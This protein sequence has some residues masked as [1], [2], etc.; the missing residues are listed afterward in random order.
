MHLRLCY[1]DC[2]EAGP[3]YFLMIH[4]ENLLGLVGLFISICDAFIDPPSYFRLCYQMMHMYVCDYFRQLIR[5]T[6]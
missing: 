4:V 1:L 6:I 2:L 5:F 3:W